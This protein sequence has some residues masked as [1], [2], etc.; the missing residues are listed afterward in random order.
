MSGSLTIFLRQNLQKQ[1]IWTMFVLADT[2]LHSQNCLDSLIPTCFA[3]CPLKKKHILVTGIVIMDSS[4]TR[5]FG[6]DNQ[7]RSYSEDK[8]R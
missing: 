7:A 6:V 8:V 2:E 4:V 5:L 3:K 1:Y